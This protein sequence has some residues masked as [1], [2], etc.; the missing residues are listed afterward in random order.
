MRSTAEI[1][2]VLKRA[3]AA[4]ATLWLVSVACGGCAYITPT[5]SL[6]P[7]PAATWYADD[8]PVPEGFLIDHQQS[9]AFDRGHRTLKLVYRR[10]RYVDLDRPSDFYKRALAA[11]GWQVQFLFGCDRRGMIFWKG[12]EELRVTLDCQYRH[13]Y[14]TSTIEVEPKEPTEAVPTV[15]KRVE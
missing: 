14:V 12:D 2:P 13:A 11:K 1:G 4:A 9:R 7:A 6:E 15:A 10:D 5:T 8:I 3:I